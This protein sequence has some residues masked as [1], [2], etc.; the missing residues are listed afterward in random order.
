MSKATSGEIIKE[1]KILIQIS[2]SLQANINESYYNSDVV[3]P[4]DVS[5]TER[6]NKGLNK[7]LT[8]MLK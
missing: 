8:Y 7:V 2:E 6:V 1:L 5:M 4:Q 3:K